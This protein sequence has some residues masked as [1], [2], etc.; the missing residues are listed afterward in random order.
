[1]D[2]HAQLLSCYRL[3]RVEANK[4]ELA[5]FSISHV[6]HTCS[7]GSD[8]ETGNLWIMPKAWD[9]DV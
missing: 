3:K 2:Q 4:Y 9:G 1:M 7:D 6:I 5:A 8:R